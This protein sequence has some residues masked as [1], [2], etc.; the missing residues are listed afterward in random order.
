MLI[1]ALAFITGLFLGFIAKKEIK[2]DP[3]LS[4]TIAVIV[5]Y[6]GFEIGKS[7]AIFNVELLVVSIMLSLLTIFFSVLLAYTFAR[8]K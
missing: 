2:I 1:L 6:V 8:G 3:V 7:K 4:A 5:F